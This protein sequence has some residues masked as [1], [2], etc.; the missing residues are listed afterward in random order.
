MNL[1]VALG[2]GALFGM[3][4][5]QMLHQRM[6]RSAIGFIMLSNAINL[7]LLSCGSQFG[8]VAAYTNLLGIRSDA[9]PQALV[10]TAIVISFAGYVFLLG[11]I[12][13]LAYLYR[14]DKSDDIRGLKH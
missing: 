13:V 12:R 3:G 14:T 5:Y 8:N 1:L 6:L 7:Y 2:I 4:I 9:L 10:L 11:L